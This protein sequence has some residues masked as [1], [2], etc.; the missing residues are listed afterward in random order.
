MHT[1]AAAALA[2]PVMLFI[3][4]LSFINCNPMH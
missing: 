1:V 3:Q 2:I 4:H